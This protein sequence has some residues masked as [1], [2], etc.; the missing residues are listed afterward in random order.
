MRAQ[1]APDGTQWEPRRRRISRLQ[2][3]IRFIRNNETRTLKNWHHDVSRHGR[4]ITGWDE[5]KGG[6]RT[7]YR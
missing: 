2:Q 7:F 3:R 4:T 1:K 6:L 5:D